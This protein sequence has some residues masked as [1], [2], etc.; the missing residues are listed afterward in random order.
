MINKFSKISK[1][2]GQDWA[3]DFSFSFCNFSISLLIEASELSS[4]SGV[5]SVLFGLFSEMF[6]DNLEEA[7]L[8]E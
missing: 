5:K 4:S 1:Q 6:G 3:P 2:A 7:E 8:F